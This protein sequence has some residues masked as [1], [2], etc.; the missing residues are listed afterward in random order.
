MGDIEAW[1]LSL[2]AEE[3]TDVFLKNGYRTTQSVSHLSQEDLRR[4]GLTKLRTRKNIY[5]AL[6][7]VARR[8]GAGGGLEDTFDTNG[9]AQRPQSDCSLGLLSTQ[10]GA[11]LPGSLRGVWDATG[12]GMSTQASMAVRS[13]WSVSLAPQHVGVDQCGCTRLGPDICYTGNRFS[14]Q[15]FRKAGLSHC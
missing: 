4:M 2:G 8:E 6:Q 9:L 15:R 7:L 11:A 13:D 10:S 1:L 12:W 3:F 14:G 5:N